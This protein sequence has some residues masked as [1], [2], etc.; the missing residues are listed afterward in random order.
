[1][2]MRVNLQDLSQLSI[3]VKRR[4]RGKG[5]RKQKNYLLVALHRILELQAVNVNLSHVDQLCYALGWRKRRCLAGVRG[6]QLT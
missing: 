6:R 4:A 2:V 5:R 3:S 1:M